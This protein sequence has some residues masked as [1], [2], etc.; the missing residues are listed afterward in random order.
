M[1]RKYFADCYY[2]PC[3]RWTPR[4]DASSHAT[5]TMLVYDVGVALANGRQLP[6]WQDSS[7]FKA[8]CAHLAAAQ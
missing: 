8:I 6:G 5:D 7:E 2:Q 1:R 4:W 3:D